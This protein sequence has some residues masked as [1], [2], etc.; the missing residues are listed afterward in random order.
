MITC[1]HPS[2]PLIKRPKDAVCDG[3]NVSITLLGGKCNCCQPCDFDLCQECFEDSKIYE[4]SRINR[5]VGENS[6]KGNGGSDIRTYLSIRPG[7][8]TNSSSY[9]MNGGP[10]NI[11][12]YKYEGDVVQIDVQLGGE[13]C[14]TKRQQSMRTQRTQRKAKA[15]SMSSSTKHVTDQLVAWLNVYFN[16]T[17]PSTSQDLCKKS[18]E[19]SQA[20]LPPLYLQHDGHSRT[21]VGTL[22]CRMSPVAW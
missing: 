13:G 7:E 8:P 18:S 1:Q 17:W 9:P 20:Y 21:I 15:K 11:E 19:T 4:K 12:G 10:K 6:E 2:M 5:C 16:L 14:T 22:C 3:C